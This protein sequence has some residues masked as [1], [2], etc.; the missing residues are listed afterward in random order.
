[1]GEKK[2]EV[3]EIR[4]KG[5]A[6]SNALV[7]EITFDDGKKVDR[8]FTG[9][10][11]GLSWPVNENPGGYYCIVAQEAARS[12]LG[13]QPLWVVSEY[14]PL[15]FEALVTRMFNDMGY[16]GAFEI[17]SD[18]TESSHSF[19][20]ALEMQRR[21]DRNLQEI[22]LKP[23]PYPDKFLLGSNA[24]TKWIKVIKGL[25][26]PRNF[27]IHSQLKGM[28]Q[29][30]LRPGVEESFYAVNALRYVVTAYETSAIPKTAKNRVVERGILPGAWT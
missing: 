17:F 12:I 14:I 28:R 23:A 24:I 29:N 13:V 27:F 2:P 20:E 19:I 16:Y 10:R 5:R 3:L 21:R 7:L 8:Q 4:P 9:S 22:R 25:T 30:D 26:I 18:I 6:R 1:M 11:V 15:T